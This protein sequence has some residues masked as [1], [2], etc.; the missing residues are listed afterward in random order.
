LRITIAATAASAIILLLIL[1]TIITPFNIVFAKKNSNGGNNNDN[2]NKQ[3]NDPNSSSNPP[4]DQS[5]NSGDHSSSADANPPSPPPPP[6]TTQLDCS[7]T[8]KD[9]ACP[10][11]STPPKLDCIANPTDPLCPPATP[12]PK[13]ENNTSSA[14]KAAASPLVPAVL[15][16][17]DKGPD[18]SCLF[19]PE[20]PHCAPDKEGKCPANFFMNGDGQCVPNK[21]CPPGFENHDNDESGTCWPKDKNSPS[22]ICPPGVNPP[23]CVTHCPPGQHPNQFFV[24]VKNNVIVIHKTVK[25]VV[26]ITSNNDQN[27]MVTR[28]TKITD[29]LTVGQAIDGCKGLTKKSLDNALKKSCNIMMAA[30]FNYCMTHTKLWLTDSNICSDNLYLKNVQPYLAENV[31][32]KLFPATIYNIRP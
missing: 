18:N 12:A 16:P 8:P 17:K 1:G 24:C 29:K 3:K 13:E 4:P 5:T 10:P 7:K 26:H 20:L 11:K 22:I 23:H 25:K 2:A 14:K 19:F 21:K 15:S 30:T 28:N 27:S 31:D 32:L 6:P 9:P